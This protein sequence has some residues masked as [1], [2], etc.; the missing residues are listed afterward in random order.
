MDIGSG[1]QAEAAV[2]VY[3]V[4]IYLTDPTTV[5]HWVR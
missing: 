2:A 4:G 5:S 1:V 3:L